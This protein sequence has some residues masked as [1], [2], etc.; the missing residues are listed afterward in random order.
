MLFLLLQLDGDRYALDIREIAEV[1]PLVDC[2]AIPGAPSG[3]VGIIDYGGEPVPIIDLSRLLANRPAH[4]RLSTRI[5]L[6]RPGTDS[7]GP[8][9]FGVI[10]ERATDT[11]RRSPGDFRPLQLDGPSAPYL[12]GVALDAE[13]PVHLIHAGRLLPDRIRQALFE[14]AASCG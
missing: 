4:R 14:P 6:I 12:S 10:A 5:V 9:L 8:K 13:G 7:S 11:V 2:Q 3:V 1:L